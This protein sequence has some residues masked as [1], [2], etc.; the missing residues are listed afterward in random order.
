[1]AENFHEVVL[2]DL[3]VLRKLAVLRR[4]GLGLFHPRRLHLLG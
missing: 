4:A 1:V 2:E 3:S